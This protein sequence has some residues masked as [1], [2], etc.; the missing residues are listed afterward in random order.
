[1]VL[2]QIHDF[3]YVTVPN[4]ITCP[5]ILTG[6]KASLSMIIWQVLHL[7]RQLHLLKRCQE[8]KVDEVLGA[9][10]C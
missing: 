8:N 3:Q 10:L 2:S 1:M 5:F 9:P 4:L 7:R 6:S